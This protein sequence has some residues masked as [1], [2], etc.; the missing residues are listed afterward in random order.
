MPADGDL[1]WVDFDPQAGREQSGRRPALVLSPGA[2]S[3]KTGLAVCCPITRQQKGYPFEVAMP[4]ASAESGGVTGSVL[5]DHV[6]SVDW[7]ERHAER[8]G[9]ATPEVVH[10]VKQTLAS[11][12]QLPY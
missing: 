3:R 9:R 4:P 2:Y 11:L 7:H 5:V 12:L 1:I 10:R 6:R 8:A